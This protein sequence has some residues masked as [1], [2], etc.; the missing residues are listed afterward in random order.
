MYLIGGLNYDACKEIICAKVNGENIIWE[1]IP[2]TSTEVVQ[3][4]QCH[5]SVA[6]GSKIY[7]FGGCFMYNK[8]RQV[9]ECTN[10]ML[11]FDTYEYRLNQCKTTGFSVAARKNHCATVFKKSMVVYGGVTE[12]GVLLN[13]MIVCHLDSFEWMKIQLK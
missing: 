7:T 6:F 9:R 11:E 2:Y 1:R 8:K 13:E 10:T 3:G 4:R 5:T 12:S